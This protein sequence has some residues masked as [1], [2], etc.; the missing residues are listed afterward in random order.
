[1]AAPFTGT[2]FYDTDYL[3]TADE[4][5]ITGLLEDK[6]LPIVLVMNFGMASLLLFVVFL[7]LSCWRSLRHRATKPIIVAWLILAASVYVFE[8]V[9]SPRHD[10]PAAQKSG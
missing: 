4:R 2:D 7:V 1:M 8:R 5:A 9:T 3:L 10:L 6:E